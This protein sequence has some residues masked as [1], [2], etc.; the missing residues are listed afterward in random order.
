MRARAMRYHFE[1]GACGKKNT[2]SVTAV[3]KGDKYVVVPLS[4][5]NMWQAKCPSCGS[6]MWKMKKAVAYEPDAM[7]VWNDKEVR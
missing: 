6:K 1:C 3:K 7:M 4:G 5:F 2:E